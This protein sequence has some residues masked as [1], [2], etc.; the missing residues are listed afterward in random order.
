MSYHFGAA[1]QAGIIV[2]D[3]DK[4]IEHWVSTV[5]AGPFFV[6]RHVP[7]EFVEFNGEFTQPDLSVAMGFSGD[8]EIEL[9][10]QH[11]DAPSPWLNF[12]KNSGPGLHHLSAW[13]TEYDNVMARTKLDGF[14]PNCVGKIAGGARFAYF[15]ADATDGSSFEISDLGV[16]GEIGKIHT[17]A[18]EAAVGWDGSQP[19]RDRK[20]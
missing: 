6:A 2:E 13:T 15:N 1:R 16:N 7:L 19:I 4:A 3:I 18:R 9:I 20:I 12:Y 8:L 10:Q 11:N 14:T 5:G 17:T